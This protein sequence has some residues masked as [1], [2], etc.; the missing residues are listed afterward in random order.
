MKIFIVRESYDRAEW[1]IMLYEA[2]RLL[3]FMPVIYLLSSKEDPW[4][5]V[6]ES[7]KH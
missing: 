5:A 4:K 2:L 1:F 6:D 7:E 3:P